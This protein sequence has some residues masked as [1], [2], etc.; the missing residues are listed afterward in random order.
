MKIQD[1]H[2][3]NLS[4]DGAE[5]TLHGVASDGSMVDVTFSFEASAKA[6]EA[7]L[8]TPDLTTPTDG[9]QV[10]TL[11]P[12]LRLTGFDTAKGGNGLVLLQMRT[13]AG[14]VPFAMPPDVLPALID[15][16]RLLMAASKQLN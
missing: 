6:I 12:P 9:A 4:E 1:L 14:K 11:R 15:R 7:L 2:T 10:E 5:V 8:C 16:L 13:P 3:F